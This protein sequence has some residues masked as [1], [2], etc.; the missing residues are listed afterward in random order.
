LW[1]G[2][3]GLRRKKYINGLLKVIE[4]DFLDLHGRMKY[5]KKVTANAIKLKI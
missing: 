4:L 3:G 2:V 1:D 5:E